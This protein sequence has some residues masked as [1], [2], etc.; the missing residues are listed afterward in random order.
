MGSFRVVA[1]VAARIGDGAWRREPIEAR[2]RRFQAGDER[3]EIPEGDVA[4]VVARDEE[5]P[6]DAPAIHRV[7]A[8]VV[9][10]AR[11]RGFAERHAIV[12]SDFQDFARRKLLDP[13]RTWEDAEAY[14]KQ[15]AELVQMF[16]DNFAQY[17][18]HVGDAVKA[19]APKAA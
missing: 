4:D 16:A 12:D 17:E 3:P 9:S 18:A 5:N 6:R 19:A 8:R 11:R 7:A 13:R 15:A 2:M 1:D 10:R 14:D